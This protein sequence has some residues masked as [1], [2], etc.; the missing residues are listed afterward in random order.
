MELDFAR[1]HLNA[2]QVLNISSTD[3]KHSGVNHGVRSSSN[4]HNGDGSNVFKPLLILWHKWQRFRRNTLIKR[5]YDG[6]ET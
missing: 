5:Q 3:A 6:M 2:E 1:G 4:V